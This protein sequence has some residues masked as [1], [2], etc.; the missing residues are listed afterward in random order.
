M[1]A[2]TLN[3]TVATSSR[4]VAAVLENHQLPDGAIAV[5]E[6]LRDYLGTDVLR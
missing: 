4:H 2:H 3:G 5:P 1:I 6:A